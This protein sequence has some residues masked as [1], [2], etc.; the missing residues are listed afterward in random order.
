MVIIS[1]LSFSSRFL[2]ILDLLNDDYTSAI[3]LKCKKSAGPV[4]VTIETER[5]AGGTLSSKVGT[6]FAY[7]GFSVDKGQLKADGS[8]VLE[9][10]VKPCTGCKVT[11]KANK[12]A[13]LGV[14]YTKGNFYATSVLDVLDTSKI[15]AT[16]SLAHPTGGFSLGASTDY[17]LAGK[18]GFNAYD[19]GVM[20]SKGPLLAAA[21]SA[22]KLSKVNISLLYKV[23]NDLTVASQT[24]HSASKACD[25]MAIGGMYSGLPYGIL[26]AKIGSNGVLCGSLVREVAPKVK[27]TL[28]GS[29]NTADVSDFKTG[30]GFEI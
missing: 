8:R 6:K 21:T 5:G 3:F 30:L 27:M 16:A 12:G 24:S 9:T 19:L 26:K 7:A 15:S 11:F 28:S 10:S 4:A 20:Y 23:N 22:S 2:S 13:D 18:T 29:V 1:V 17:S 14:E 25:V